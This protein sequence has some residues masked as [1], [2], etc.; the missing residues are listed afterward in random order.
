MGVTNEY[1]KL[2]ADR[3]NELLLIGVNIRRFMGQRDLGVDTLLRVMGRR[4]SQVFRYTALGMPPQ[5]NL[6]TLG[7]IADAL[8]VS[9]AD[10]LKDNHV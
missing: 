4:P 2:S 9:I 6:A 10:L 3:R 8:E 7:R 1:D 5:M